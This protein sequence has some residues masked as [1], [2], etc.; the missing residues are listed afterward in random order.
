MT[1]SVK[2]LLTILTSHP[3]VSVLVLDTI[4]DLPPCE[5]TRVAARDD[6]SI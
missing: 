6:L 1:Q 3:A 2:S 5:H 4:S